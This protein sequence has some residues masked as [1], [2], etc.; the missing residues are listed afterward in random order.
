MLSVI[1]RMVR[2]PLFRDRISNCS[3]LFRP[4]PNRT[5]HRIFAFVSLLFGN[6]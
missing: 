5:R 2:P 1:D 3:H 6:L 4:E